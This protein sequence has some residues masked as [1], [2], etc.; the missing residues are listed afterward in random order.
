MLDNEVPKT[1]VIKKTF[2]AFNR[3]LRSVRTFDFIN[4]ASV[5]G[6]YGSEAELLASIM[7]FLSTKVLRVR[8]TVGLTVSDVAQKMLVINNHMVVI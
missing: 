4:A 8:F 5:V 2:D 7:W 3:H 1:A 6:M